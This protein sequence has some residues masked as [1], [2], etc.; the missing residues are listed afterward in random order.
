MKFAVFIDRDGTINQE[1]GYIDSLDRFSILPRVTDA[2]RKLNENN[3]PAI[4]VTN[5]SGVGRGY[6]SMEFLGELH[7]KM[8]IEF[9][10]AG[11][12]LDDIYICPH[13]PFDRCA[14]RKPKPGLLLKAAHE[15]EISLHNSYVIGDKIIDIQLA[16]SAGA[17]GILV[18][19]GYGSEQI[20]T[21]SADSEDRPDHVASNLYNAVEWILDEVRSKKQEVRS[22]KT[23]DRSRILIIKPSSLGDIVHSLPVLWALR[24]SHPDAHIGWVVKEVWKDILT[25]NPLLDEIIILKKGI[26]GFF[27]AVREIRRFR[28]DT[29]L[30]LQGLFRS[31]FLSYLSGG[32]ERIGFENARELSHLFYN[33]KISVHNSHIHAVDRYLLTV[34]STHPLPRFPLFINM[35][36][37]EWA[38]DFLIKNNLKDVSPLIAINPSARWLKKR[39][40]VSLYAELINRLIQ[41]LNAGIIILG[42]REDIPIAEEIIARV[43]SSRAVI[44][45]GNTTLKTLTALLDRTDLLITNDSGPMHIAAALGRPVVALFGATDPKLTGPYGDNHTVIRKEMDCSPCFRKPCRHGRPLC[46]EAI[47]VDDVMREIRSRITDTIHENNGGSNGH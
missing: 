24:T 35:E 1:V 22:K 14:C 4:M 26:Q 34:N 16:H 19:T 17:K 42:S 43:R 21:I 36:D 20:R 37:A 11:C 33:N 6:F 38:Q 13:T 15:H 3:I 7:N 12:K 9:E 31:G 46:M 29:I 18:L 27:S 28:F 5:Q 39:W 10:R 45:A 47:T 40:P 44:A 30:D 2:I 25:G 23:E 8:N 32:S 41:E